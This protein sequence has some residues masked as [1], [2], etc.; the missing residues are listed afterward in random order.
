MSVLITMMVMMIG[1]DPGGEEGKDV[2]WRKNVKTEIIIQPVDCEHTNKT[3]VIVH[4]HANN[5]QLRSQQRRL[6]KS[7]DDLKVVFVIFKVKDESINIKVQDEHNECGDVL[8]GNMEESYYNLVFKHVMGLRWAS[9]KCQGS[10]VIKMDDDIF[11]NFPQLLHLIKRNIPSSHTSW[12]MGLLQLR[13]PVMRASTR[14]KWAVNH[15]DWSDETW[16]DFLSGWCYVSS[17]KAVDNI[18]KKV[19]EME[20]LLWIDDVL[21]TGIVAE[22]VDNERVSL[23]RYFTVYKQEMECCSVGSSMCPFIVGPTDHN[24]TLLDKLVTKQKYCQKHNC[25]KKY[26]CNVTNPYFMPK[27]VIGEVI[28]M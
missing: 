27:H 18:V 8:L 14:S 23:N 11:V 25:D 2:V 4:S 13:L 9:K 15:M 21:I 26:K 6:I 7:I 17:S 19:D 22:K 3:V 12:M 28:P 20:T 5:F 24:V 16:P 10:R 1:F